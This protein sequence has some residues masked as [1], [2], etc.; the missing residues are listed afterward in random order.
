MN[1]DTPPNGPADAPAAK[2]TWETPM[3]DEVDLALTEASAVYGGV[4]AG[5]YHS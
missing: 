2:P 3:I 5:I 1:T 4:D